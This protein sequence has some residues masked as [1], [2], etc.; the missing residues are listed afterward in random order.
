MIMTKLKLLI[1]RIARKPKR[2]DWIQDYFIQCGAYFV[3]YWDRTGIKADGGEIW[4][5]NEVDNIP[6]CFSLTQQDLEFYSKEFMRRRKLFKE[7]FD[8]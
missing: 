4:I 3:A 8:I 6:Q 5:A 1:I 7:K 2:E